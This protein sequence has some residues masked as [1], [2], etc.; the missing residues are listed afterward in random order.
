MATS[1]YTMVGDDF[2]PQGRTLPREPHELISACIIVAALSVGCSSAMAQNAFSDFGQCLTYYS[3]LRTPN[4]LLAYPGNS[5]IS[6]CLNKLGPLF[7]QPPQPPQQPLQ[8]RYSRP[9]TSLQEFM[10]D[11]WQCYQQSGDSCAV[12]TSCLEAR[13]YQEDPDGPLAAPPGA[14]IPCNP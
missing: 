13:G 12:W 11:R 6:M 4:G 1:A 8:L 2:P 10:V 14:G 9:G 5:A 7:Q 3:N